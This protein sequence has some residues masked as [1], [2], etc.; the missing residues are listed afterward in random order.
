ML[1]SVCNKSKSWEWACPGEE[2]RT[3]LKLVSPVVMIFIPENLS[4]ILVRCEIPRIY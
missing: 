3:C 1:F 2:A 4:R